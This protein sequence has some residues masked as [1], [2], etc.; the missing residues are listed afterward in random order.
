MSVLQDRL[1]ALN[2]AQEL[3]MG[4]VEMQEEMAHGYCIGVYPMQVLGGKH[5]NRQVTANVAEHLLIIFTYSVRHIVIHDR[6]P[7]LG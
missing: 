5:R 2:V 4:I 3:C 7:L 6:V 1:Y